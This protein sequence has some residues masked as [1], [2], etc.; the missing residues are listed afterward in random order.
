MYKVILYSTSQG[1][2]P[3][4]KYLEN[5][6]EKGKQKDLINI[7]HYIKELKHH[8]FGLN[9]R[10]SNAYKEIDANNKIYELRPKK[11]RIFFIFIK[12]EDM[13]VLL[14]AFTKKSRKTPKKEIKRAIREANDYRERREDG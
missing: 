13:F 10:M 12:G 11:Y 7:N 8:G 9:Q 4:E 14:H 2:V 6:Q 3:I 5:L 1:N